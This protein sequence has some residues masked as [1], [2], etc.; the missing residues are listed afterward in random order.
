VESTN[1]REEKDPLDFLNQV[2]FKRAFTMDIWN[3][4][5]SGDDLVEQS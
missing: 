3:I 2:Q 4:L 1:Y 5:E